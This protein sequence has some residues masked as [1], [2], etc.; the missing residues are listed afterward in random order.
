MADGEDRSRDDRPRSGYVP[1]SPAMSS[2]LPEELPL[3][4]LD[5][6]G[7][8]EPPSSIAQGNLLPTVPGPSPIGVETSP[9]LNVQNVDARQVH[10]QAI[11]VNQDRSAQVA[12]IAELRH[13]ALMAER[14]QQFVDEAR[15]FRDVTADEAR[16]FVEGMNDMNQAHQ[17]IKPNSCK[18]KGLTSIESLLKD[19]QS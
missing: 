4:P 8:P 9:V 6:R 13:P 17:P 14:G 2:S 11:F 18:T 10:Q 7:P 15:Q 1:T 3:S 5:L 19:I 16:A 12:Q